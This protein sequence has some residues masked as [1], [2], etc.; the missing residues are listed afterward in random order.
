M[1]NPKRGQ[2]LCGSVVP[3]RAGNTE[4]LPMAQDGVCDLVLDFLAAVPS[5]LVPVSRFANDACSVS[6]VILCDAAVLA[7]VPE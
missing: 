4:T 7:I 2:R 3:I 5:R 6:M 1:A